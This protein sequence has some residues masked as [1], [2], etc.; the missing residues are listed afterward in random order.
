MAK[1]I[2]AVNLVIRGYLGSY[3]EVTRLLL[4]VVNS[5]RKEKHNRCELQR[6]AQ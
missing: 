4:K 2:E 1:S 6:K 5:I 3:I